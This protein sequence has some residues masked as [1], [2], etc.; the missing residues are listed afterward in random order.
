[1]NHNHISFFTPIFYIYNYIKIITDFEG[2][3]ATVRKKAT[4]EYRAMRYI[5]LYLKYIRTFSHP[6][7][8]LGF[9]GPK[10]YHSLK[11]LIVLLM[12]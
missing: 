4:M 8:P 6:H 7:P 12:S 10:L 3:M 5:V 11:Y 1:M 9:D 2:S